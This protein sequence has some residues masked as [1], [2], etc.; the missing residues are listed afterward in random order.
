MLTDDVLIASHY[1]SFSKVTKL[2]VHLQICVQRFENTE[3]VDYVRIS[4]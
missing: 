4:D 2:V 3:H 1:Y